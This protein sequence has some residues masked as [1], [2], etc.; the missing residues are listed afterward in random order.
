[1]DHTLI[2]DLLFHCMASDGHLAKE[3]FDCLRHICLIET[4]IETNEIENILSKLS[5]DLEEGR[6]DTEAF[7]ASLRGLKIED[8]EAIQLTE[9]L[10]Q[11][12]LTDNVVQ[13]EEIVY[14]RKVCRA[15]SI[16]RD[17]IES[18]F[19]DRLGWFDT[20]EFLDA[21]NQEILDFKIGKSNHC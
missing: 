1:M 10:I 4:D 21:E 6:L 17:M 20:G 3:E 8:L 2:I 14:F 16:T 9:S 7:V 19:P 11:M 12:I 13:Y 18:N 15:L 5:T